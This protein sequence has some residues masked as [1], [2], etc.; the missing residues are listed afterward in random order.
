MEIKRAR[1]QRKL[2]LLQSDNVER[3]LDRFGM[4]EAK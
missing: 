1:P 4:K 2:W 3:V